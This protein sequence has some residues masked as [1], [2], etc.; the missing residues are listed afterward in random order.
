MNSPLRLCGFGPVAAAAR[1]A[2]LIAEHRPRRV[3]LLG[4]VGSWRL[5]RLPLG[6]ARSFEAVIIDGVGAGEGAT[7]IPPEGLGFP[8]WPGGEGTPPEAVVDRLPLDP[9]PTDANAGLLL[10][11]CAASADASM[12]Q[13]RRERFEEVVAEDMEAFGVALSCHQA[14]VPLTVVRGA[15]NR[16]GE[17]D[18]RRWC[19]EEALEAAQVS[20]ARM[21]SIW[22]SEEAEA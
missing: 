13:R 3:L 10:T 15:S 1:S 5:D 2:S 9:G 18:P 17:R 7:C 12:A 6:A 11:V 21:L 20:A 4:I 8:Q 22:E 16:V 14:R 19:I